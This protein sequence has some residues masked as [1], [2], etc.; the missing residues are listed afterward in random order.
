MTDETKR[1]PDPRLLPCPHCG[2]EAELEEEMEYG[3]AACSLCPAQMVYDGSTVVL[4][5]MWNARG[6]KSPEA[7]PRCNGTGQEV[8][9]MR[10]GKAPVSGECLRCHGT[11]RA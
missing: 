3:I 6:G 8:Y 10:V 7:C 5:T 11:G 1:A 4:I 2:S 9:A